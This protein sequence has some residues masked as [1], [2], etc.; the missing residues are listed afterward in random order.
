MAREVKKLK[1]F[2]AVERESLLCS[3]F[4]VQKNKKEEKKLEK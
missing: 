1:S 4:F 3:L 2:D